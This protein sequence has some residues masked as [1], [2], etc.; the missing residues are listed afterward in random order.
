M[1]REEILHV[2]DNDGYLHTSPKTSDEIFDI[3]SQ[4]EEE[5]LISTL[6]DEGIKFFNESWTYLRKGNPAGIYIK[7]E[8]NQSW[9]EKP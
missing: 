5:G 9:V 3:L 8:R 2:I 1:T 4:L 6:K 7:T